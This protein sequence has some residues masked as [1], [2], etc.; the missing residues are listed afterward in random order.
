MESNLT[1][2][3]LKGISKRFGET[4][5][6]KDMNLNIESGEFIVFLGPSGCGKSTTMRIIAGLEAA[7]EGDIEVDGV[8][9]N[10]LPARARDMAMVFQNYG[11]Y[12]HMTVAQNIAYPLRLRGLDRKAQTAQVLEVAEKVQLTPY[13]ERKPKALSGGQRQRVALARALVRRPN[14]FLLDE[15]LSNLDAKLRVSMRTELNRL[16]HDNGITTVYV[17][18]D[19]IEAMTLATR[20]AVMNMGRIAQ[21]GTP[22]EIY[23]DPQ[24]LFV[25]SFV[26]SPEINRFDGSLKNGVFESAS[27]RIEGF[28]ISDAH[29]VT[30]GVRPKSV[31]VD[32]VRPCNGTVYSA[33]Y[34]GDS[35]FV[36]VRLGDGLVSAITPP[37]QVFSFDQEIAVRFERAD[38]YLFDSET[39]RRLRPNVA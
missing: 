2:I 14:V 6:L 32:E 29:K 31:T 21:L 22:K 38:C 34:G 18:H 28:S 4:E 1:A 37:E 12:P 39:G 5:V 36:T 20:V 19:Q 33:E 35:N 9:I 13:L 24:D 26:G 7:S 27:I 3:F 16:H 25:A 15:P 17:T 30:L 8:R 10:D 23:N 11:L